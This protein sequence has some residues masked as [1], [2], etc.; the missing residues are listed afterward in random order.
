MSIVVIDPGHGGD[1]KVGGSSLKNARG[2]SGFLE[3]TVTSAI[4][5]RLVPAPQAQG[6][7]AIL[8]RDRDGNLG[9]VAR[10]HAARDH[11]VFLSI[12]FNGFNGRTQGTDSLP[13][14]DTQ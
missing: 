7:T 3:K 5:R 12:H 8:T 10:A 11:D 13:A 1:A 6:H 14:R 2:Q 9:L 4:T